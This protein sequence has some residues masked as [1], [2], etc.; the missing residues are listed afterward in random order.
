MIQNVAKYFVKAMKERAFGQDNG[1]LD[2][3][4]RGLNGDS[5]LTTSLM[6]PDEL[7]NDYQRRF[8]KVFA[9]AATYELPV[10]D[11]PYVSAHR[12]VVSEEAPFVL[13]Q[14]AEVVSMNPVFEFSECA[15]SQRRSKRH[16]WAFNDFE[17]ACLNLELC[18]AA[19]D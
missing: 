16:G 5:E 13:A 9:P 17:K 7:L 6:T 14:A 12:R 8:V 10:C 2:F 19:T 15:V 11:L 1:E 3:C 18:L 4:C